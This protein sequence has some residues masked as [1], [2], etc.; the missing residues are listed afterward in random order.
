MKVTV[1]RIYCT[2]GHHVHEAI[3]RRLHDDEKVRGVTMLRAVSGFG[4]S[5]QVHAASL[6][7]LSLDQPIIIEFFDE[8]ARIR[9]ILDDLDDCIK[10]GHVLTFTAELD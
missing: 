3:F 2:E 9:R 1:A 7:D 10:T 8:P 4:Q 5:G 6:I